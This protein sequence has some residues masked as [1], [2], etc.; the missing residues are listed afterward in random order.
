M[1]SNISSIIAESGLNI[2]NMMNKSYGDYAY[3]IIDV[4]DN[5]NVAEPKL[6]EIDGIVRIRIIK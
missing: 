1:L 2:E 6:S 4:D 3:T 5:G